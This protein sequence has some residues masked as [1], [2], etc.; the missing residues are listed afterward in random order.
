MYLEQY[1][2]LSISTKKSE[3]EAW[4][5]PLKGFFD[6]D[7][8]NYCTYLEPAIEILKN[9]LCNWSPS[10]SPRNGFFGLFKFLNINWNTFSFSGSPFL[11]HTQR[12]T[13]RIKFFGQIKNQ[14]VNQKWI[15]WWWCCC[16][17][18]PAFFLAWQKFG[19]F[20]FELRAK[21]RKKLAIKKTFI[22]QGNFFLFL[23]P[24]EKSIIRQAFEWERWMS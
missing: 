12:E 5:G 7:V 2:L 15:S 10:Q 9:V 14:H 11:T 20:F 19:K 8:C 3:K 6:R 22:F 18:S 1:F 24:K 16:L 17:G 4:I 23:S 13:L 21:I